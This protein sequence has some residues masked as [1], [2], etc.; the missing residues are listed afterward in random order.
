MAHGFGKGKVLG[1]MIGAVLALGAGDARAGPLPFTG[2]LTLRIATLPGIVATGAGI[3]SVN[4]SAGGVHLT[5]LAL[6]GGLLGPVTTSIPIPNNPTLNS[7]IFTGINN[8]TGTFTGISG[9]PPGGGPMGLSGVAKI[10]I[11]F[12]PCAYAAVNIPLAP[13]PGGAGFGIGGTA[14][15]PGAVSI[16]LQHAPW[17]VGLPVMTLHTP[18]SNVTS[19]VLPGGFAHGPASLTSSTAQPSGV[20]QLVTVS[21]AYTSLTGAFPEMPVVGFLDL[22][23]VVPE[24]GTLLPGRFGR[25]GTRSSRAT[26]ATRLEDHTHRHTKALRPT[27]VGALLALGKG[28]FPGAVGQRYDRWRSPVSGHPTGGLEPPTC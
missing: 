4:G 13:T 9:G 7:V 28:G 8:L 1:I 18:N 6:G 3:G 11:G 16:T 14:T 15:V 17:T 20:L 25:G 10:C 21:K 22:H 19:P 27:R 12:A 23:F 26:A 5:T 2:T 24:P